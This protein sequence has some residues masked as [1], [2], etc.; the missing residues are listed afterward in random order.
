M[1]LPS[2][3]FDKNKLPLSTAKAGLKQSSDAEQPLFEDLIC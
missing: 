2:M 3:D 1:P